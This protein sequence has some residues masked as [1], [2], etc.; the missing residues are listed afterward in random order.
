MEDTS[1][2]NLI[3][4]RFYVVRL[5]ATRLL[6]YFG[7]GFVSLLALIYVRS[8]YSTPPPPSFV[9]AEYHLSL[10]KEGNL[11]KPTRVMT[12][13]PKLKPIQQETMSDDAAKTLHDDNDHISDAKRQV[14]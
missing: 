12:P 4:Y 3:Y 8:V 2:K 13:P 5:H 7:G 6:V 1:D 10:P 11:L 9:V 14:F